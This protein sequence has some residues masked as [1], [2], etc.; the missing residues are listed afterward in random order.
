MKTGYLLLEHFKNMEINIGKTVSD[1][2]CAYCGESAGLDLYNAGND[3]WVHP[4]SDGHAGAL[5]STGIKVYVPRGY[6]ALLTERGS[7]CKTP[8][9]LRAGV[10]DHGYT[11]EVFV[12][13]FNA[14][15][16]PCLIKHGDK[17]PFQLILV[18]CSRHE[19]LTQ[20]QFDEMHAS[21]NR[22]E[23]KIGSSN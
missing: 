17:L 11:G 3:V 19:E 20:E 15:N 10:I 23:G 8:L 16:T 5:I 2:L 6:V 4:F 14:G 1:K 18:P 7:V 22:N 12:A 9:V 21:S 13:C